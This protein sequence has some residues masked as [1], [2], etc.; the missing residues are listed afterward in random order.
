MLVSLLPPA[1]L[2][3]PN[4]FVEILMPCV[5]VL[6]GEAFGRWLGHEG[7]AV[8]HEINALIKE[9]GERVLAPSAMWGYRKRAPSQ[10]MANLILDSS[11]Q[12]KE[13]YISVVS[14]PPNQWYFA[15]SARMD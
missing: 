12:K 2:I 6:G 4:S 15:T 7:G 10:H 11:L 1:T 8:M 5:M 3:H 14:K 13:K 9:V